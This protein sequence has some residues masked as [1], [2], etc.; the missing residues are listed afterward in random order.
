MFSFDLSKF[1]M[2]EKLA[3]FLYLLHLSY[4]YQTI[5]KSG[6]GFCL[7]TN[8]ISETGAVLYCTD[9]N[10]KFEQ[11]RLF[12]NF[13]YL[14]FWN[15]WNTLLVTLSSHQNLLQYLLWIMKNIIL[16]WE[17]NL[18]IKKILKKTKKLEYL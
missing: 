8:F 11:C 18:K 6:N 10:I 5:K 15:F 16:Q 17:F 3:I 9:L 4:G 12:S 13:L 7:I 14:S 2:Q 1:R